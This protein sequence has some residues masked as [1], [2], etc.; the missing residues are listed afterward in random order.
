MNLC[1]NVQC[2]VLGAGCRRGSPH[3]HLLIQCEGSLAWAETLYLQNIPLPVGS[4]YV[5]V[6]VL[7]N[8]SRSSSA[9][10]LSAVRSACT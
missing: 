1:Q 8:L 5:Y 4:F 9:Y 7:E 6:H 10:L 3:P 2:W